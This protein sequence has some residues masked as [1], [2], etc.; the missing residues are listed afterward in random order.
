[1]VYGIAQSPSLHVDS[2]LSQYTKNES[3]TSIWEDFED[4][5]YNFTQVILGYLRVIRSQAQGR[6]NC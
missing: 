1:M 5:S 6:I 4:I 3:S 2:S